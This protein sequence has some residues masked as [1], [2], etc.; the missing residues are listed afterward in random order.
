MDIITSLQNHMVPLFSSKHYAELFQHLLGATPVPPFSLALKFV[1]YCANMCYRTMRCSD[2]VLHST[3]PVPWCWKARV[4]TL[5]K[6]IHTSQNTLRSILVYMKVRILSPGCSPVDFVSLSTKVAWLC[7]IL[8]W[9]QPARYGNVWPSRNC[10]QMNVYA[11]TRL[12]FFVEMWM[13]MFLQPIVVWI[14]RNGRNMIALQ[15]RTVRGHWSLGSAP[16]PIS[17]L[18]VPL[19]CATLFDYGSE[20]R[21]PQFLSFRLDSRCT[22]AQFCKP[23]LCNWL[24]R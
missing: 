3:R 21:V 19:C 24:C 18:A 10:R 12:C 5:C 7:V 22:K 14:M 1:R 17:S 4:V 9:F 8:V 11:Y 13:F 2:L 23:T 6:L 16:K 15:R 20:Y